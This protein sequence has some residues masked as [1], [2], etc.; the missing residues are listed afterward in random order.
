LFSYWSIYFPGISL[1]LS[2]WILAILYF[3]LS[4]I[5]MNNIWIEE[6]KTKVNFRNIVYSYLFISISLFSLSIALVFSNNP[7][8]ISTVW[9]FEATIL[10]YF[11]NQT[12]EDK[13]GTLWIIL[14]IIGILQLF[15][16]SA[17]KSQFLFLIPLSLIFVSFV[18]NIKYLD[19]IKNWTMRVVHDLFHILW[20]GVIAMFILILYLV[21]VIDGLYYE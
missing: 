15:D 14:F 11:Y 18:L 6:V 8:I 3:I 10:F 12:K 16:L 20:I 7:E 4:Y 5:M 13:I 2:F 17:D 1:G 19:D 21:Q 9:L